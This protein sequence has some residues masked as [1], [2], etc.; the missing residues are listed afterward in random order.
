MLYGMASVL[1]SCMSLISVPLLTHN[2]SITDYGIFEILTS[3][4]GVAAIIGALG[5]DSAFARFHYET[6]SL[7]ERNNIIR[8]GFTIQLMA[9][10]FVVIVFMAIGSKIELLHTHYK[11]S[12]GAILLVTAS[13]IPA[14][15]VSNY[16]RNVLKWTFR[17]EQ[18]AAVTLLYSIL[19]IINYYVLVY[20][21]HMGLYGALLSLIIALVLPSIIGLLLFRSIS[22]GSLDFSHVGP[23]LRFGVPYMLLGV[24]NQGIRVA[25][26]IA[27]SFYQGVDATAVYAV[28][29]KVASI[30]LALDSLFHMSWGPISLAIFK[31]QNANDT[32]DHALDII[33][34]IMTLSVLI[35][36]GFSSEIVSLVSPSSFSKAST[37]AVILSVGLAFQSVAGIAS[38]GIDLAKKTRLLVL[39]WCVGIAISISIILIISPKL[40]MIGVA[41]GVAT[42]LVIESLVRTLIGHLVYKIKFSRLRNV[43]YIPISALLMYFLNKTSMP[44]SVVLTV[45]ISIITVFTL[46]WL[47]KIKSSFT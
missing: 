6:E 40:G 24:M 2:I 29:F 12:V 47:N 18:Y 32:Y 43:I 33:I 19:L 35:I 34:G 16:V 7:T 26:K 27:V 17:R 1:Y 10:V 41:L 9:S 45:K 3:F 23:M 25:D 28:G 42:G 11:R 39:S 15:I 44:I 38:I 8:L 37:V 5:Q 30:S 21:L 36:T 14:T 22:I 4:I 20:H 13:V 31:E 46:F